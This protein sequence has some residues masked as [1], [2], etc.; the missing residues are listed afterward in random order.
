MY[1]QYSAVDLD[2]QCIATGPWLKQLPID[3][4]IT[5][6]C[7]NLDHLVGLTA[8]VVGRSFAKQ[9]ALSKRKLFFFMQGLSEQLQSRI[10]RLSEFRS[11]EDR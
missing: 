6:K 7:L 9:G 5:G 8:K 3:A 1:E 2:K 10:M 11:E 4:T